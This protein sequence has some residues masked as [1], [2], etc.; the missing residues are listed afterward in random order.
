MPQLSDA[1]LAQ[2]DAYARAL[3][4]LV[5]AVKAREKAGSAEQSDTGE[6]PPRFSRIA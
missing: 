3:V 2:I 1:E 4:Q 6:P 5:A